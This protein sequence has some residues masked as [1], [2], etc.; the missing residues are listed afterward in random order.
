MHLHVQI[1]DDSTAVMWLF[2]L[3]PSFRRGEPRLAHPPQCFGAA[4]E[5]Q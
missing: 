2:S 3:A 4:F 1:E 5:P